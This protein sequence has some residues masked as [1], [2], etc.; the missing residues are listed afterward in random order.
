MIL[1]NNELWETH[2]ICINNEN[3]LTKQEMKTKTSRSS[4][5]VSIAISHKYDICKRI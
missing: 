4:S 3:W 1:S 5:S 2:L